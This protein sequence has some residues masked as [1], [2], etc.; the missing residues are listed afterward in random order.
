MVKKYG[1]DDT[2][3]KK[4]A[5]TLQELKGALYDSKK[6]VAENTNKLNDLRLSMAKYETE[7]FE[8]ACLHTGITKR[9]TIIKARQASQKRIIW[10]ESKQTT[11]RYYPCRNRKISS[12][13]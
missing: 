9:T 2:D 12:Q 4:A 1:A 7:R 6:S 3:V 10:K 11:A 13:V 5:A 8:N